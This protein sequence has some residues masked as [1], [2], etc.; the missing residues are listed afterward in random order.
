MKIEILKN[1]ICTGEKVSI[2]QVVTTDSDTAR[3]LINLGKA[4]VY[5]VMDSVQ[6]KPK[7]KTPRKKKAS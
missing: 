7:R 5:Q 6:A 3:F 2:G 4:K 1:T